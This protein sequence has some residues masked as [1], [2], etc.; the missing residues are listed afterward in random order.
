MTNGGSTTFNEVDDT[1]IVDSSTEEDVEGV[2]QINNHQD[3][4]HVLSDQPLP[5]LYVL[6]IVMFL[7]LWQSAF[8]IS[9][10]A[11]EVLLK[12]LNKLLTNTFILSI[13]PSAQLFPNSYLTGQK[14]PQIIE[15]ILRH[16]SVVQN[17]VPFTKSLSV[18]A[19]SLLATSNSLY[20]HNCECKRN[21]DHL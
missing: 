21:V 10:I 7:Y 2:S 12:F 13:Q 11:I 17:V 20:I 5:P 3:S 16:L 15:I 9:N 18:I 4:A 6:L 19:V 14:L 8:K 1:E